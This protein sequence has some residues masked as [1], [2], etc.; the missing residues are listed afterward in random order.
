MLLGVARSSCVS[1]FYWMC[2]GFT[3]T[4]E[5]AEVRLITQTVT[6]TC[7]LENQD[8]LYHNKLPH[9]LPRQAPP[10]QCYTLQF[11]YTFLVRIRSGHL[12]F[13]FH[14]VCATTGFQVFV[15]QNQA[16]SSFILAVKPICLEGTTSTLRRCGPLTAG[17]FQSACQM[18]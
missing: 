17:D 10:G 9:N 11:C 5:R 8:H 7:D 2:L 1:G 3:G 18:K 12:S 4:Q 15:E 6:L 14:L 16:H 13:S